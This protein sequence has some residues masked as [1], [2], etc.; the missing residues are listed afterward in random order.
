MQHPLSLQKTMILYTDSK[1]CQCCSSVLP[2][3]LYF[4]STLQ[5]QHGS[6]ALSITT[7]IPKVYLLRGG[8]DAQEQMLKSLNDSK[9]A[10]CDVTQAQG[11]STRAADQPRHSC[12]LSSAPELNS[13]RQKHPSCSASISLTPH[14]GA[15]QNAEVHV[16]W[17]PISSAESVTWGPHRLHS[18]QPC[19]NTRG[20]EEPSIKLGAPP[21]L[22]PPC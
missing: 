8:R 2:K 15:A 21:F 19:R 4:Q 5:M 10:Q 1:M 7:Y 18:R 6:K 22:Q 3:T 17:E 14:R 20:Q 16:T 11:V 13:A 9:P 12:S